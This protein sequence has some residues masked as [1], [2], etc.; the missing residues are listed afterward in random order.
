MKD[1]LEKADWTQIQSKRV[2]TQEDGIMPDGR[3]VAKDG[4]LIALTGF[5]KKAD[6][7]IKK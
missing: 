3:P 4:Y 7:A 5:D 2:D 1:L 6:G